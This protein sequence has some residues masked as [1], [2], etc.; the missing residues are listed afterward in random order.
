MPLRGSRQRTNGT[1][2]SLRHAD[3]LSSPAFSG[4]CVSTDDR[5]DC[6]L[7]FLHTGYG[8]LPPCPAADAPRMRSPRSPRSSILFSGLSIPQTKSRLLKHPSRH[9]G[10]LAV[11]PPGPPDESPKQK[12]RSLYGSVPCSFISCFPFP[13]FLLDGAHR[14]K[15]RKRKEGPFLHQAKRAPSKNS[16]LR[17]G[18]HDGIAVNFPGQ[19]A[20]DGDEG[21]GEDDGHL[22]QTGPKLFRQDAGAHEA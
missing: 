21:H 14:G 8:I 19:R 3:V 10:R 4:G 22:H 15:A 18:R 7:D 12:G 16:R 5:R 6:P 20:I 1:L 2:R 17:R 13:R 11:L 9:T